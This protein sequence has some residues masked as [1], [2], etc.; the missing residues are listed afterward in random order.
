MIFKKVAHSHM[1]RLI[2]TLKY[3]NCGRNVKW[4]QKTKKNGKNYTNLFYWT[5]YI[6]NIQQLCSEQVRWQ[7]LH[8]DEKANV[9]TLNSGSPGWSCY[10]QYFHW[11]KMLLSQFWEGYLRIE[12]IFLSGSVTE[13]TQ[14]AHQTDIKNGW[15]ACPFLGTFYLCTFDC[16]G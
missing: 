15:G 11:D 3:T 12:G 6:S 8:H 10:T 9:N 16:T 14:G 2:F 13:G 7:T 5:S 1:W 4:N